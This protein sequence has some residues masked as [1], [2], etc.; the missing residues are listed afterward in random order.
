M[1]SGRELFLGPWFLCLVFLFLLPHSCS[2]RCTDS[3]GI[4][5]MVRSV[6][7]IRRKSWIFC[8]TGF[9]PI[10]PLPLLVTG[11]A[12]TCHPNHEPEND[13]HDASSTL[14]TPLPLSSVSSV[15]KCDVWCYLLHVCFLV[16]LYLL[17]LFTRTITTGSSLAFQRNLL[18][19]PNFMKMLRKIFKSWSLSCYLLALKKKKKRHQEVSQ[20][21]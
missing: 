3:L 8:S 19:N 4:G 13:F 16:P 7:K 1:R 18:F 5:W 10:S 21:L 2:W 15:S 9:F 17:E 20:C 14:L 12:F 11:C 6:S